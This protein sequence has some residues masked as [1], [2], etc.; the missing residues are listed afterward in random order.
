MFQSPPTRND[1]FLSEETHQDQS[2][3][4]NL[5]GQ[6]SQPQNGC[7]RYW[8]PGFRDFMKWKWNTLAIDPEKKIPGYPY[9]KLHG[10]YHMPA[11]IGS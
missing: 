8:N 10:S 11:S 9:R 3:R 2:N 7:F 5:V 4:V 6:N 1:D